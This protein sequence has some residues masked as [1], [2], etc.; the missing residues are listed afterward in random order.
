MQSRSNRE[1]FNEP[2]SRHTRIGT[3]GSASLLAFA[4][5]V[6]DVRD[7]VRLCRDRDW[8][9]MVLGKGSNIVTPDEGLQGAMLKLGGEL[10]RIVIDRRAGT[11]T[12]GG[13]GA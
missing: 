3:G 10:T 4:H 1:L 7:T 6:E 5:S 12:A 2:L 8:P 11:V 9:C 13:G